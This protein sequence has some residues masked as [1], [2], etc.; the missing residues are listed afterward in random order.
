MRY[1]PN[2]HA[3]LEADREVCPTCNR[4]TDATKMWMLYGKGN[5]GFAFLGVLFPF[6]GL[7]LYLG[8]RRALPRHAAAFF[9]GALI[10]SLAAIV[11]ALLFLLGLMG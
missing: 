11:L 7:V 10:S 1:C 9:I 4:L 5:I 6:I 8:L 2:C 3:P